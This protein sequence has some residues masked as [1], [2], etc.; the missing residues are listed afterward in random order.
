M[1]KPSWNNNPRR[2]P[3][4]PTSSVIAEIGNRSYRPIGFT[5]LLEKPGMRQ[6]V[7]AITRDHGDS[8]ISF[9]PL[10]WL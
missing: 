4:S 1:E 2:S 6:A 7:T 9:A 5:Q 10:A 8:I 3:E